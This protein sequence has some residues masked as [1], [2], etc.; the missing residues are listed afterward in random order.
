MRSAPLPVTPATPRLT[1]NGRFHASLNGIE[2]FQLY[3][4][5][6]RW[7]VYGKSALAALL[8]LLMLTHLGVGSA[9][10][11]DSGN[12]HS[13][14][15][16]SGRISEDVITIAMAAERWSCDDGKFSIDA[17]RVLIRFDLGSNDPLPRYF[18]SRRSALQAVHLLAIDQDGAVRQ[19]SVPA[20]ALS[21]SMAGGYFKAPLPAVTQASRQIVA[22]IDLPS[23]R[24]TLERAYLAPVDA[25]GEDAGR[26][27]L[28][29]I[30][31]GLARHASYLQRGFLSN[32]A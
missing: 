26:M 21:S 22:A 8:L 16:V 5:F 31:A 30:L 13:S 24:M 29:I 3:Q 1:D 17:E 6:M 9:S 25:A 2:S 18:F 28:L 11:T 15:W 27:R 32:P 23:H 7:G 12:I 14:C 19:A 10:A 4:K 20:T